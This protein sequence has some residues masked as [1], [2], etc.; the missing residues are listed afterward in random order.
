MVNTN[1][2]SIRCPQ[3]DYD[4]E[5]IFILTSTTIATIKCGSCSYTHGAVEIASLPPQVVK[6]LSALKRAS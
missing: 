3:C 4:G 2:P 1:W 5:V 6:L